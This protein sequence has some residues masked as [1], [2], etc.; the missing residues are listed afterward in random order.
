MTILLVDDRPLNL[1]LLRIVLESENHKTEEAADGVEAME[2]LQRGTFDAV[3]TDILMPNMDGYRLC[4][5]IR[6]EPAFNDVALVVYTS[7]YVSHG[8]REL[9]MKSGADAY[10]T[11]PSPAA[12]ILRTVE[13]SV[14]RR[15]GRTSEVSIALEEDFLRQYNRTLVEKLEERNVELER[16]S[17]ILSETELKFRTLVENLKAVLFLTAPGGRP[18]QYVSPAYETMWGLSCESLYRDP[19]SWMGPIVPEDLPRVRELMRGAPNSFDFEFRLRSVSG[20]PRWIRMHGV[21]ALDRHGNLAGVSGLAEDI[22]PL[23]MAELQFQQVQKMEGIGRLAGGV[24]HDFNNIL[25][26][27]YG[28]NALISRKIDEVHP[29]RKD[30]AMVDKLI[31]RAAKLTHQLLAFSRK[32]PIEPRVV[33]LA[34][35][36][37][38]LVNMLAPILGEDI[39]LSVHPGPLACPV[40]VDPGQMEQ[41]LMNLC[42]NA[43]DAMPTGGQ[44]WLR[45]ENIGTDAVLSVTDT[46]AGMDQTTL[47]HLFE[48]FFTTKAPGT[49]TGLGLATCFGI[50]NQSG[51]RLEVTSQ[52]GR[53]S[54]FRVILP[55]ANLPLSPAPGPRLVANQEL[56]TGTIVVV[57]DDVDVGTAVVQ[58]LT[59]VGF[60]VLWAR[61]GE[62]GMQ[63]LSEDTDRRVCLVITDVVMPGQGG[64][65][66]ASRVFSA[67]PDVRL[68]F[69]SGYLDDATLL[70]GIAVQEINFIRKPFAPAALVEK[71]HQVL[72][73]PLGK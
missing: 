39:E 51:G 25:T 8:D 56:R 62:E 44:L 34:E 61:S 29:A 23:K 48:P 65:E 33:D 73:L 35:V 22:T 57:E 55:L 72:S 13:D 17:R 69:M 67:R 21:P 28:F 10:L 42:V 18:V 41:V 24:A 46:G 68:L 30:V 52:L 58:G 66:V 36:L 71:V 19:D 54:S 38:G 40:L 20:P 5:T 27:I 2:R 32:Q 3:I 70:R 15:R 37:V 64:K 50:V 60:T 6:Q 45:L 31:G 53:G 11:K 14:Q 47:D 7:T 9:A 16:Q 63:L 4:R 43:R 26:A 12:D 1:K 59:Q 49:G